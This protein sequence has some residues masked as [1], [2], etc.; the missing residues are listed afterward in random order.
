MPVKSLYICYF[1]L[2]EP[3]VQTQVLPYLR[4]IQKSGIEVD[5]LTFERR[6]LSRDEIET[7]KKKLAA[8]G[9]NWHFLKYH[10]T[11]S[12]PAT[13]FDVLNGARFV[14][15][16]A[17][18]ENIDVFHGRV[19]IPMMMGWIA[20]KFLSR[21]PKLLFDIRGFF[22]DE[23]VDA[24][25]WKA[26][27]FAYKMVKYCEKL[28]LRDSDAFVVLTEKARDILFPESKET[29]FDKDGRPV[30]VVPC[31]VDL[32]RFKSVNDDTR[33]T[34]REKLGVNDRLVVAYVGSFGGFY[35]TR[36]TA[37]LYGVAKQKD[38]KTFALVLTQTSREM[39]EPLLRERGFSADDYFIG[40]VT[41]FEIPKYLSA[42]DFAV[43]FIK[44]S[45]SKLASSPT[46]NA[47]YLAS[48]LPMIV[49]SKVGDTEE[50][51]TED[52]T[53]VVID[54]FS[55]ESL[56]RAIEEITR[57]LADRERIAKRCRKSASKR[58]DLHEIGGKRYLNVYRKLLQ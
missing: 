32:A 2:C 12:V 38:A 47:E 7:S 1:G 15:K 10:K 53:G 50:Q 18:K 26:N 33:R 54:D 40:T 5:L 22:P 23:Y 39:I 31:C 35:M 24:G 44:P 28:L 52:K 13:I 42:A 6:S 45:Y 27:S 9:I 49:N 34:M 3:L 51:V 11:P 56:E 25:I 57:L 29:G 46:K 4:E 20:N 41:P 16:L 30:E 17:R 55:R 43:S 14:R 8:D 58:F 37:D 48:G 36:E 21:K 19:H